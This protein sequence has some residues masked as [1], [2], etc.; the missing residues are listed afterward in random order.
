R[1]RWTCRSRR[2]R[3]DRDAAGLPRSPHKWYAGPMERPRSRRWSGRLVVEDR[4]PGTPVVPAAP[5]AAVVHSDVQRGRAARHTDRGD[6]STP[7]ERADLAPAHS[8]EQGRVVLLGPDRG[9]EARDRERAKHHYLNH[10]RHGSTPFTNLCTTRCV[11]LGVGAR[12]PTRE[13]TPKHATGT[14]AGP[15]Q[16]R[17]S[18]VRLRGAL[19]SRA[20]PA[21]P[22]SAP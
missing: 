1:H 13:G 19:P 21:P 8:L 9:L 17:A 14:C 7:T 4:R 11:A 2:P 12:A 5:H 22:P 3:T 16:L 6:R 15:S 18:D 20:P 10:T